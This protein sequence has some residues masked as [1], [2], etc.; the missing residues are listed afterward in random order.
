LQ[1]NFH[2]TF[3]L[4]KAYLFLKGAGVQRKQNVIAHQLILV[5]L[6][7][8]EVSRRPFLKVMAMGQQYLRVHL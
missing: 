4:S 5:G 3:W 2:V 1:V 6:D 7:S 8:I